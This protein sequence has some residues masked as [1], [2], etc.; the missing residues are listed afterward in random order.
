MK[1]KQFI[2]KFHNFGDGN[3]SYIEWCNDTKLPGFQFSH[4]TGFN[5]LTYKKL[6]E[7]LS[8]EFH[9]RAIDARGHGFT[10]TEA[11]PKNMYDWAIYRDDLIRSVENFVEEKKGPIILGGHSM[12]GATIMQVAAARPDLVSGLILIEPV[13]IP[14]LNLNLIKLGRKF[15]ASKFFPFIKF[16]LSRADSTLKRRRK[17]PNKD[18]I[19]KSYKGRGAFTTWQDG[20]LDDYINGGTEKDGDYYTL[21]CHPEWEA[22]TFSSWKHNAMEAIKKIRCPITLLQGKVGST[23]N[24]QGVQLLKKRD[25]NGIF[26]VIDNSSHFL[27]MEHPEIIQ[28][29]I[30][31]IKNRI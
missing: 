7:P 11:I 20:F 19:K 23:T 15:P 16:A 30:L 27:P 14:K 31:K 18:M 10:E 3:I 9:I 1:K 26:K 21:T 17:F 25:P 4:A 2:K 6:L 12:G 22:A 8:N 5:S 13:L 29:E 28:N 24:E